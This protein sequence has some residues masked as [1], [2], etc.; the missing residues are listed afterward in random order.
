MPE[1]ARQGQPVW[2]DYVCQDLDTAKGF[3]STVFGWDIIDQGPEF[4]HYHQIL[5]GETPVGGFMRAMTMDG[6][7]NPS[8]PT[9]WTTYLHAD[10]IEVTYTAAVGAGAAAVTPPMAVG[11][12]GQMA[13]VTDPT[14]AGVG[15]WQP[16]EFSGFETPLTPGT[17][18]WFELMT[19]DYQRATEFYRDVFAWDL[20]PMPGDFSYATHGS[21]VSAV[22][23]ICDAR[24]WTTSSYW[25]VYVNVESADD[26]ART[27][28]DLGGQLLDGPE[29]TPFGRIATVAD[30]EG[31][32]FQLHQNL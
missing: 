32:R 9:S 11:P 25:R 12:L 13:V 18:V 28:V 24:R 29:D 4:G 31:A 14:G 27:I 7:P 22:A 15:L 23:G 3:Y 16:R 2:I 21:G 1:N 30:P 20:A 5:K 10:D 6:S 17:P 8:I 19:V 26:A